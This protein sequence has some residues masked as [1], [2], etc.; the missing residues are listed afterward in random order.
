MFS[1]L[2]ALGLAV[3]SSS[4][5]SYGDRKCHMTSLKMVIQ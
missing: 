3:G 2:H 4:S 5:E 1:V